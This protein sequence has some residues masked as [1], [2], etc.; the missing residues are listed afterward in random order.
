MLLSFI[1]APEDVFVIN[2]GG[3]GTNVK[4]SGLHCVA[5]TIGLKS[6]NKN[7]NKSTIS[8]YSAS[9]VIGKLHAKVVAVYCC[10]L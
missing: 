5:N 6:M 10:V 2:K 4:N 7:N 8:Y 9:Y 1:A 3:V